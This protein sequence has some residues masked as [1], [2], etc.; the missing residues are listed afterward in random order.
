MV[1]LSALAAACR[2]RLVQEEFV[3]ANGLDTVATML[4]E[5][6]IVDLAKREQ[7]TLSTP[8]VIGKL[9]TDV[10]LVRAIVE[11][12]ETC[13]T[14]ETSVA[15]ILK[16]LKTNKK[17]KKKKKKT[18]GGASAS[19][20]ASGGTS[21]G[22]SR[23]VTELPSLLLEVALSAGTNTSV[24]RHAVDALCTLSHQVQSHEVLPYMSLLSSRGLNIVRVLADV[25]QRTEGK[26]T[27]THPDVQHA[28]ESCARC[29]VALSVH[30]QW[31]AFLCA[32]DAIPSLL[33]V[34]K[35]NTIDTKAA[36]ANALAALMNG[37]CA[38]ENTASEVYVEIRDQLHRGGAV[39][40]LVHL[41]EP[42]EEIFTKVS[43]GGTEAEFESTYSK[44]T[45]AAQRAALIK[46]KRSR[47]TL[48]DHVR[49]RSAGL[50]VGV[51]LFL[52]VFLSFCLFF[53]FL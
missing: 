33:G 11:L 27:T 37:A 32:F 5:A 1:V 36:R 47:K 35:P 45:T 53:F 50:L 34:L 44:T 39:A 38:S 6:M 30:A 19:G 20:G 9:S 48:D 40:W 10:G 3:A 29:I 22:A 43:V 7:S 31:R 16:E 25:L 52:F 4:Q 51:F 13:T 2:N 15:L 28:R 26:D 21:G 14:H 41:M 17:K 18:T 8:M 42:K 46:Q 24:V 23:S 12:V 49:E